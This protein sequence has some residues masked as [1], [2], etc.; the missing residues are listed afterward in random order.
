M[1]G[2]Q[3]KVWLVMSKESQ[4]IKTID[5][6]IERLFWVADN[7]EEQYRLNGRYFVEHLTVMCEIA[8]YELAKRRHEYN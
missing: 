1:A 3:Q 6:V 2:L 7:W 5:E 4:P 8:A